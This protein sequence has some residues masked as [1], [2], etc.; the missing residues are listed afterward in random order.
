MEKM[1]YVFFVAC[2][3]LFAFLI[4]V[5][6]V[7]YKIPITLIDLIF[8]P[9]SVVICYLIVRWLLSKKTANSHLAE[10]TTTRL[11]ASFVI[12][13]IIAIPL[14][15]WCIWMGIVRPFEYFSSVRGPAHGYTLGAIGLLLL[16]VWVFLVVKISRKLVSQV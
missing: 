15:G 5:I 8:F 1:K 3:I 14:G 10:I 12:F 4:E 11:L 13:S 6:R 9:A 7:V 16:M 2:F